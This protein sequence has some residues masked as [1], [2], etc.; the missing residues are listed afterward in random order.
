MPH[1]HLPDLDLSTRAA[2]AIKMLQPIPQR[3]WGHA[4]ELARIHGV[5]RQFL[6]QLRERALESLIASLAPRQPGPQPQ[7]KRLIIDK[8]FIRRTIAVLPLLKGTV[9]DIQQGL[10]LLFGVHR[11]VGY[12][13]ETLAAAGEQAEALNLGIT[14]PLPILGEAD[15]IFQGRKPCLTL[16][17]GRSFL[18]LNLTPAKSRDGPT[19]G[20]TYLDL[21]ERGIQFHDLACDGGTGLR[22]GVK[23]AELAIPLR[24]DLFH[25]LQDAHRLTRRLEGA[26]Y[27]AIENTERARQADLEARGIIR[28]RGRRL[29]VKV[30]LSQAEAEEAKAIAVFDNWCWLLSEV[31]QALEPVTSDQHIVSTAETKATI[32]VAIELLKDL[33]HPDITAFADDLQEKIPELLAP[34]EW[35]EQQLTPA[36][37]SLDDDTATFIVWAWQRHEFDLDTEADIPEA[38]R[39][40]ANAV[41]DTLGLFH[42]SSSLAESL[43]S[44]LRPYLQIHRGVPKWLLPLLQLFWNHHPFERGKRAGSSPVE[45]AGVEGAP[46][47]AEVVDQLLGPSLAAQLT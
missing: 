34:L 16:V 27:K 37:N 23:E 22:A 40:V 2:L 42:R 45:L 19:W 32:E 29:K 31:R 30:P 26:A 8:D 5:S 17:D 24:P 46:S 9:R 28:R 43:H 6:Y 33:A 20:V 39:P 36:L 35:L 13:S 44:W 47:L 18:V 4:T 3:E 25:I 14:V 21:V 1:Y 15:E 12:L 11:S 10:C 41:W 7:G 38:L